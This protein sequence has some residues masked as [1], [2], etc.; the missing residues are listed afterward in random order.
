MKKEE[1]AH[2]ARVKA[3]EKKERANHLKRMAVMHKEDAA[4]EKKVHAIEA[5]EK[6]VEA[7]LAHARS[8][9]KKQAGLQSKLDHE[10]KSLKNTK[11]N[12]N[13]MAA[14]KVNQMKKDQAKQNAKLVRKANETMKHFKARQAARAA[15]LKAEKDHLKGAVAKVGKQAKALASKVKDE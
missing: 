4:E 3:M 9:A 7:K 13:K 10:K 5:K 8:I 6:S 14:D 12:A 2:H 11:R 1:A 15:A